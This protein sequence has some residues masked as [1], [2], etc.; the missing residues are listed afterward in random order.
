M[1]A[2]PS[3]W[4]AQSGNV[5]PADFVRIIRAYKARYRANVARTLD[6][7]GKVD[8]NAV[9]ADATN[10]LA[11]DLVLQLNPNSGYDYAWLIQHYTTGSANWHQMPPYIIGM[12]DTSGAY[13]QW[14]GTPRNNRSAFLIRTPDRRF[15]A[16][17][18]RAVQNT[19][20]PLTGSPTTLYFRNRVAGEDQPGAPWGVSQYDFNRWRALFLAT[21]VGP[22]PTFTKVENDMLAAE[23]YIRTGRIADAVPLINTSRERNNLSPIS[24]TVALGAPISAAG[25]CVP[26]VPDP[27]RGNAATK[28]GDVYEAMKYEK[29]METAYA[30][31]AVW[32]FDMRGWNDLPAWTPIHWPTPTQERD[33]RLLPSYGLGGVGNPGAAGPS[34]YGFGTGEQ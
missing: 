30:G 20:S 25:S 21:R 24:A 5:S 14:L 31:Y 32:Y 27:A 22:W 12:A 9:I 8:W 1:S 13:D 18:T 2:V 10:G 26:R 19:N 33:A 23:G 3:A 6:E 11:A 7:R 28:C 29:R 34:T 16:G 17:E 15:P 4:L